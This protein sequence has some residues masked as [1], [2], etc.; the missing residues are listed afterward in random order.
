MVLK[1]LKPTITLGVEKE[2]FLGN[3]ISICLDSIF[4]HPKG[5]NKKGLVI[6][7]NIFFKTAFNAHRHHKKPKTGF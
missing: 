2:N 3:I 5:L 7:K 1:T 4:S 6:A